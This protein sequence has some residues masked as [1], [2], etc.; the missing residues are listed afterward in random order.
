MFKFFFSSNCLTVSNLL[1]VLVKHVQHLDVNCL[2]EPNMLAQPVLGKGLRLIFRIST[3]RYY[4]ITSLE[5]EILYYLVL[6]LH[7][8]L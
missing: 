1:P 3:F 5:R 4:L 6:M 7:K 8:S 2:N